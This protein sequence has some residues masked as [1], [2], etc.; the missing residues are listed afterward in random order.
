METISDL[1]TIK[2]LLVGV[3]VA[4]TI[5][6]LASLATVALFILMYNFAK[7]QNQGKV[8]HILAEEHLAKGEFDALLHSVEEH[9]KLYPQ[10]A[11]GH[12]Y[13]AQ[14]KFHKGV[15]PES[16][17]CFKRILELE[18]GW[19]SS[20]KAWIELVEKKIQEGPQLVD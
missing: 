19:H 3:L 17:R 4:I 12:W 16:L 7:E 13:K 11:W 15:Y 20:V 8:F 2:W 5:I 9:L 1:Q 18:P 10:D 6:A 14:V